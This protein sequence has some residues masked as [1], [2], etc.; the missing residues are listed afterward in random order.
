MTQTTVPRAW[1]ESVQRD[2]RAKGLCGAL[3]NDDGEPGLC[4][5]ER[6]CDLHEPFCACPPGECHADFANEGCRKK[7]R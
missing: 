1:I 3:N 5:R 7:A 4:I 6:P 2:L